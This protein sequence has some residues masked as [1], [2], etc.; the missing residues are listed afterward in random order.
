MA[1][2]TLKRWAK[3]FEQFCDRFRCFFIRDEAWESAFLY[4]RGLLS[5]AHRKNTW[6]MAEAVGLSRPDRLQR[7]LTTDV[8]AD[9]AA[10]L[11]LDRF[12]V[13]AFGEEEAIGVLD[14]SGFPK[15]GDH[16]VGVKRQWC[17]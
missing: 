11:E 10:L 13:E 2:E 12:V 1:E 16:S 8:W 9:E 14:E 3:E 15:R 7:V 6:Q 4:F 17:G 5:G